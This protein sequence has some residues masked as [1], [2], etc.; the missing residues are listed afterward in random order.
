MEVIGTNPVL[1]CFLFSC[2][3][4]HILYIGYVRENSALDLENGCVLCSEDS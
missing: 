1:S 4:L 2:I 3:V